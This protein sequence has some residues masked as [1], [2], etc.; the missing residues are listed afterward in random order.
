MEFVTKNDYIYENLKDEIVEGRLHPGERIVIPDVAKRYD[1]S[2]MP[3]RE[4]LNRLQ[5]DGFI[6]MIPH[7]GARVASFDFNKFKEI[8]LIRLELETLAARLSTPFV[9]EK[10][11]AQLETIHQEM[12]KCME[13]NDTARYSKLN[14]TFHMMIYSASPYTVLAQ[15]ISSLWTKS[16]FSR[17]VFARVSNRCRES[18]KEHYAWLQAIKAGDAEKASQILRQQKKLAT[19]M[20]II[21]IEK[22]ISKNSK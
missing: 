3:I 19:E 13:E 15:L 17:M 20:L 10:M 8:M 18:H 12:A 5:Q 22:E 16:E 1:V 11:M 21:E 14:K 4:A 7:V 6:E 2:A 9:N